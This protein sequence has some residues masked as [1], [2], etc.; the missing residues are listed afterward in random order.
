MAK[1]EKRKGEKRG[2]GSGG[3]GG[4]ARASRRTV[5]G[6]R[7]WNAAL[8]CAAFGTGRERVGAGA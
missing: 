3:G 5:G 7:E 1:S 2:S 8:G 6:I 4:R